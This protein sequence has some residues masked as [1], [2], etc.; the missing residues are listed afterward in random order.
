MKKKF[1]VIL[2]SILALCMFTLAACGKNVE[3]KIN[4]VVDDEVYVTISTNGQETIKM[5][6]N[7]TKEDYTFDGWFWDKDVWEK[8]FTANSL[9]D[10]PLSSDMS[11]YAKFTKNHAH[12]YTPVVTEPTCTEKGYTTYTCSCNDSYVDNYVDELGH[13]YTNYTYNN[14]AECEVDGTETAT[15]DNGCEEEDTRVKTNSA[16]GHNFD[17]PAFVW[18]GNKCTAVRI[19]N[20]NSVHVETETV[21]A[22]YVKDTDATCTAPEKGH[23]V[24]TFIN[25][26]FATQTTATNSVINGEELGHSFTNYTYNND[27]RCG[28]NGTETAIC[29][30]GCGESDTKTKVGTALTHEYGAWVTNNNGTHT[31][32][33]SHDNT[34]KETKDCNGGNAT[35]QAKAICVDCGTEYGSALQ[36]NFGTPTYVWDNNECTATRICSRDNSHVETETVTATYVKDTDATCAVPEKGH[37][38]ATFTNSAFTTQTTLTNSVEKGEEL[39]HEYGAWVTNNN[40][41]HTRTCVH[42]TT[43]KETKDCNGGTATCQVKA[44]CNDCNTEYGNF[45]SHSYTKYQTYVGA[46][47][48]NDQSNIAYCDY[49]CGESHIVVI[50]DSKLS[51]EPAFTISGSST[52]TINVYCKTCNETL[53]T[54]MVEKPEEHT[55]TSQSGNTW[56]N[57]PLLKYIP[58]PQ[59]ATMTAINNGMENTPIGQY[60]G[61]AGAMFTASTTVISNYIEELK[62]NATFNYRQ[63]TTSSSYQAYNSSR[64]LLL[65]VGFA[66]GNLTIMIYK[67]D[68]TQVSAPSGSTEHVHYYESFT[69]QPTVTE[70]GYTVFYCAC[71][72]AYITT[73]LALGHEHLEELP[74]TLAT[75]TEDGYTAGIICTDCGQTIV[76]QTKIPALGHNDVDGQCSRCQEYF[77]YT[78]TFVADGITVKTIKF[79]VLTQNVDIPEVPLKKGYSGKWQAF[80]LTNKDITVNA[81]YTKE[82]YKIS[83]VLNGG[84]NNGSNPKSYIYGDYKTLYTPTNSNKGYKFG[85]WF[86]DPNFTADSS[87]SAITTDMAGDIT[88]YAQWISYRIESATGFEISYSTSMP[89]L[90]TTVSSTTASFDFKG[91]ITVSKNCTY[92]VYGDTYGTI[93]YDMKVVPLN[94]EGDN[95]F[96]ISVF[97]PDGEYYTQY[98]VTIYKLHVYTY[99]FKSL[100]N[101][102]KT[103]KIEENS[104]LENTLADP[105]TAGYTFDGWTLN[106]AKVSFPYTVKSNVTFI[107]KQD[108]ITCTITYNLN[109]GEFV[110]TP[111]TTFTI[112]DLPFNVAGAKK[113]DYHAV[114]YKDGTSTEVTQITAI[115]DITLSATYEYGTYGITY[116]L[117]GNVLTATGYNGTD[118]R[119][120]FKNGT[121]A[122]S[123]T[124]FKG[125]TKITEIIIPDTVTQIE[126]GTLQGC[127]RLTSLTIPFV[128][129]QPYIYDGDYNNY[130]YVFGWIF[131]YS[132]ET[133]NAKVSGLTYQYHYKDYTT[134]NDNYYHYYIPT[135]LRSVSITGKAT[136]QTNYITKYA[137]YNCSFLID[138]N[139]GDHF[140][141]ID[142]YAFYGCTNLKNI[143][144]P[145]SLNYIG[146]YSFA[147]CSSLNNLSF[148][149]GLKAISILAFEDC[150]SLCEIEIPNSVTIIDAGAF[151]NCTSLTSIKVSDSVE[152][153]GDKAFYN[154]PIEKAT[155][156]AIVISRMDTL[157]LKEITITSG[158]IPSSAFENNTSLTKV[159]IEDSVTSI[160]SSAFY[161]CSSL[162]KVNYTGTIDQWVQIKFGNSSANPLYYA[163]NSYINNELVTQAVITT[164]TK[165]NAYAF[166]NCSSLTSIEIPDS[167]TSIGDYA[168]YN[169]SSLTSVVIGDS[170]TSIG[171]CAFD[172]CDSLTSVV[173]GDS[174]TSIGNYAF[175]DCSSLTSIVIG[176]SVTSIGN[177]AFSGCDSLTSIVIPDSVTSIGYEAFDGCD[178]LTSVTIGNSVT[179][180]GEYVF[181]NCSSLT[182]ITIGNNVT[183]IGSSAFYNCSSLT[184]IV[185]PDNVTSIGNYAFS[186]CDSLTSIVIPDSVTSIGSY[187]F[188]NCGKLTSVTIGNSVTSISSAAF[189]NCS[190]LTSITLPFV[191]ASKTASNGYDQVFG[192][193][194]GYK[195]SS[196]SSVSGATCQYYSDSAYYHYYIPTSLKT[197]IITG[198]T[199]IGN[200]AFSGCSS[201]I[202]VVIPDSVTS[203][204]Y[205]AFYNCSSLTSVTIGNSVTSIGNYAF[206]SCSSLTSVLIPDSVTSIG[207]E[208]FYNC[209]SLTSVTI[210]NSVTSIGDYAFSGC[211]SLTNVTIGNSVTSIGDYAFSGCS[212][213]TN[214]TI[215][216]SVTSIGYEAFYNCSSLTSVTIGN[217]VTSIGNYA[218]ASCSSLTSVVIPN[219]VISIGAG[220][221][222]NCTSLTSVVIGD[223][224]T[225]IG[226]YAFENCYKLVEVYNKSS[227]NITNGSSSNGYVGYYALDIYNSLSTP[228][229]LTTDSNE[230]IIYTDGN[231]K[232]LV[233]YIG[234]ETD[235]ILPNGITAIY[236]YAFYNCSS[237]TSVVIPNSVTS[238]GSDA[239]SGCTGLTEIKFNAINCADLSGYNYVFA[240]AGQNGTGIKVTFGKNVE[241]VPACLFNPYSASSYA[242]KI[243][244]V[245][246]EEGSVCK[247]IG[248]KAFAFCSSLTSIEIPDSV[249]SIG[250]SAFYDCSSLTSIE[251]PDS[252]TSIGSSAFSGC[253]SLTSI[254]IPDSVTSI[255]SSAFSGCYKLVEVYNKSSLNITAGSS[256]YGYIGYYALN[257]Y[258]DT[259]GASKLTTD[260]NGYII[261]TDGNDKIL[262][263]YVG[264]ETDL[265]LP[266]DITK[267]YQDAF[268]NCTSLTS[269]VIPNS[270]T[271]I[272]EWAFSNCTSLTSIV[273][274]NSVTSIGNY[275][276]RNC[277]SLTSI[278][279]RGSQSQWNAISKGTY[280]NSYTGSYKI[281][282]NYTSE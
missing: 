221:F 52:F 155:I 246:F 274:P 124:A 179:S 32:T 175:S 195:T 108:I 89:T 180:I 15:C 161:N 184:S 173:I 77:E 258:T 58:Y 215:G 98:K 47:C 55:Q 46:T 249:T 231:D 228:S 22:T 25:T 114:W 144:L 160:G 107:A 38:V 131:G 13:S 101:T 95:I 251:I 177:Y 268:A 123:K 209:S 84:T 277:S 130:N 68:N 278:K 102:L 162:T 44:I 264:T 148:P 73:T 212:S 116:Q 34:H 141:N 36:H 257:I 263:G 192:Y 115:E 186:G 43:H 21:T 4:F 109:G 82:T 90:K 253:S 267:I 233:G 136:Y 199:S 210:G 93:G 61:Q 204:G 196:S 138:V 234:S 188:Y 6:E 194:F 238:I 183:S 88:L 70:K 229:K 149:N 45:A 170:V 206:R 198:G 10:A 270:V 9:L 7:P 237:L 279:Y 78:L 232:I 100:D 245:V 248:E 87:I 83:Y 262:V 154:C 203:I 40:G 72:D 56:S 222:Y 230:Y 241:K 121:G 211:S 42:D 220:A 236:R 23:Y 12:E 190:S 30:N 219:S 239:F 125:N 3:F 139:I 216:N 146:G 163:E 79:T 24:A 48:K 197:V 152:S 50:K 31:R 269:I 26:A 63:T 29:D 273:I 156:P 225:S 113:P 265:T 119:I 126:V 39:S 110:G 17:S 49:G 159:V 128:G 112:L 5:P 189:Y 266:S 142:D 127:S 103:G 19:C 118:T 164:A 59:G 168:F 254:E 120:V 224:V 106:G 157:S 143:T 226:N 111:K 137:F 252:V 145:S 85:G 167:V 282:Y 133:S 256:S 151:I 243:T 97:H 35:C 166:S 250:S 272:G 227:L 8:P 37:Y 182:S 75:C 1:L 51:H 91:V 92:K 275:A 80:T 140:N 150:V 76:E 11:V 53:T 71:K 261:Y 276:F 65:S 208:A 86:T 218:F 217:S 122:I 81:E 16:L 14:N 280:W 242:P 69:V 259:S 207:Y 135:S 62:G 193:I 27:A 169:C 205:E 74:A 255:G 244:E 64:T 18:N 235:L 67:L 200:R 33:C 66:G 132:I 153:I 271:S 202:S 191:G 2:I 174:V 94:T 223:S 281:T 240:Y 147:L 20:R 41:T 104:K 181:Y 134:G 260:S 117:N 129:S 213:L 54:R 99:T 178:S 57:N 165:I 185:I 176:D 201:L 187:A 171:S 28:I 105:I 158:D 214:V 96:Y 60:Y 247:S 172:S